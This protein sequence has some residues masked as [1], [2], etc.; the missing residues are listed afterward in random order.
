MLLLFET[1]AGYSLFKVRY[2]TGRNWIGLDRCFR[3]G[4]IRP[5]NF[6][7]G[8]T[9]TVVVALCSTDM[10]SSLL[11]HARRPF[12]SSVSHSLLSTSHFH[13]LPT[14]RNSPKRKRMTFTI[15]SFP[16]MKRL[17]RTWK[18]SVSRPLAIPPMPSRP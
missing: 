3:M 2:K 12:V 9:A 4:S 14:K 1:P 15:N 16:A 17:S 8:S 18:W 11:A 5:K 7:G 13:R 10:P 6:H